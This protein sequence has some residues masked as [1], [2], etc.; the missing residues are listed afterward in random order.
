MIKKIIGVMLIIFGLFLLGSAYAQI[1]C[2]SYFPDC[3][4]MESWLNL[5]NFI[6]NPIWL[7]FYI[8]G[9]LVL[10]YYGGFLIMKKMFKVR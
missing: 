9:I 1:D 10:I 6:E 3:Y 2:S 7:V 4:G 5:L 8:A